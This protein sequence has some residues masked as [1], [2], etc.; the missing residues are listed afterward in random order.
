MGGDLDDRRGVLRTPPEGLWFLHRAA[1]SAALAPYVAWYW[2]VVW[3]LEGRP[4]HH[5]VTVPH[6]SSHLVV[7]G[8]QALLHGVPRRRFERDLV[9]TGKVV[10]VRFTAGGLAALLGRPLID[11]PVP[12]DLLDGVDGPS[13]ALAVAATTSLAQAAAVLEAVLVPIA[14]SEPDP[15][16]GLVEQAV[17]LVRADRSIL[18]VTQLAAALSLSVR[19]L[20][21]LFAARVGVSPGWAIRRYRIQEAAL[22]ASHGGPVNWAGLAVQLGYADQAHLI[23]DFTTTVGVPPGRYVGGG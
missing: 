23:R 18:R 13:L 21:R 8:E 2:A 19:S 20:Q 6:V 7:E 5:Q 16:T 3:N 10:G 22:A 1:P 11:G 4:P 9:G 12:A 17:E 14:P 15:A